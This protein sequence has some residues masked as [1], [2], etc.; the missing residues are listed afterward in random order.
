MILLFTK[1]KH[2]MHNVYHMIG[3]ICVI[4]Y[5]VWF[6]VAPAAL[7]TI[8]IIVVVT[9]IHDTCEVEHLYY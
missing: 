9:C 4:Q 6:T 8:P 1:L 5:C 3:S 7:L 2:Y